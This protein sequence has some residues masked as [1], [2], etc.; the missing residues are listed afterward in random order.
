MPAG[1]LLAAHE[2]MNEPLKR[3]AVPGS[4]S[5][6]GPGFDA[7]SVALDIF[8]RARL[9]DVRAD[10]DGALQLEFA[11][12]PPAGENRIESAYA[13]AVRTHGLP[14]LGLRAAISNE[15]PIAAGLGSSAAA[16]IVGVKLYEIARGLD[17]STGDVLALATELEGHPDNAAAALLGGMT[18]SCQR[19]NGEI[20]ARSWSWPAEIRF[21][22]AT[23]ELPL[24]TKTARAVL[25]ASVPLV[26]AVA[27]LQ[28]AV[29]LVRAIE[30]GRYD[31]LREALE[32]RWH[33]P[34]RSALVPGL[35][36]ALALDDPSILGVCLSGAGPSV[37]ALAAPG[38]SE[39]AAARLGDVYR[40]L[41][42]RHTIR[43]LA[44]HPS[45][46]DRLPVP[47]A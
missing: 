21:V 47:A 27:N 33:Q 16:T 6:L 37:V 12:T 20:I 11:G 45:A 1:F 22:V 30:S 17:L 15:I 9:L 25:P 44:A 29:L 5:N 19:G 34:A 38:R 13:L 23:P 7:L 28:R 14:A 24:A 42:V 3:I 35:P 10:L 2:H 4:T 40:R 18:V 39:Q 36:E 32:D 41:G 26:D 31:D 43:N 46:T 8:L